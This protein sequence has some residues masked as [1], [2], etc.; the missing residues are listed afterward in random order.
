[1]H[2]IYGVKSFLINSK[3]FGYNKDFYEKVELEL[4]K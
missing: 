4:F 3:L 1:M 2:K